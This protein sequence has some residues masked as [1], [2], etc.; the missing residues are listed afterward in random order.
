MRSYI[1]S[2]ETLLGQTQ[3]SS[4]ELILGFFLAGLREDV[5]GQV[6]IQDPQDLMAAIRVARDVEDTI[7]QARDVVWN[8]GEVNSM[9]V[10][11]TSTIVRG[12]GECNDIHKVS[13]AEGEGA[14]RREVSCLEACFS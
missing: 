4:K 3:G 10:R 8:G 2:F 13:G 6:R 14:T 12:D 11:A 7:Q 9:N 5:K 1:R